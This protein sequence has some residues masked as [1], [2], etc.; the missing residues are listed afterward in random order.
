MLRICSAPVVPAAVSRE[1][2]GAS[3]HGLD[4]PAFVCSLYGRL[5]GRAWR[6]CGVPSERAQESAEEAAPRR[7][8]SVCSSSTSRLVLCCARVLLQPAS[9]HPRSSQP[10]LDIVQLAPPLDTSRPG[11][12]RR[13][14][15]RTMADGW[16][17]DPWVQHKLSHEQTEQYLDRLAL[18]RTLVDEPPSLDLLTRVLVSHLEQVAKDTSPLHVPEEQWDGPSTPIRLSSA[19]TNMP[20]S[21]GSF[22]RVVLQRK[23]AF[24]FACV[25]SHSYQRSHKDRVELTQAH[26]HRINALFASLLRSLG[27]RV[28]ELAGR[29]FKDLG[30]DP[31][32]KPEGWKWGTLTHELLVADWPGS[33]GRW[34][35]RPF[36]L[37][38]G[39]ALL[40]RFGTDALAVQVDGAWGPWSCS[41][42]CVSFSSALSPLE[43]IL[44][45]LTL[46]QDQAR[47]RRP[48][49]RPQPVRGLPASTR[50]HPARADADAADR[51]RAGLDAL[52]VHPSSRHAALPPSHRLARQG[53][54]VAPLP[55]PPP[56]APTRRLPPLPP[57]LGVA[58]ARELHGLLPRHAPLARHWRRTTVAHVR[59]QGGLAEAGKGVHDGRPRGEREPRGQGRRVGRHGDR[60]DEGVPAARVW[61]RLSV[62]VLDLQ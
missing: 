53:L 54:L 50:A 17:L 15:P 9:T 20:E 56:L 61:L 48:D 60:R 27:F 41:V 47:R 57:L 21:T 23:G 29:T 12:P 45:W 55:L 13:Q 25:P 52:P 46:S 30:N 38:L 62:D 43:S 2:R 7:L 49:A 10:R 24:C 11:S 59:R 5:E 8:D 51:Q 14:A 16:P 39:A 31:D 4:Q 44:T 37:S 35:V 19:F 42:P 34:V 6:L 3:C 18:P 58:R 33:D 36:S 26:A 1:A 22:D 40:V 28:S 32:K